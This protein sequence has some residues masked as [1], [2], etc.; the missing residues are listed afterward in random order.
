M[1]VAAGVGTTGSSG[2]ARAGAVLAQDGKVLVVRVAI[3]KAHFSIALLKVS[4][5]RECEASAERV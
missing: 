1:T 3:R 4:I 2:E 5:C